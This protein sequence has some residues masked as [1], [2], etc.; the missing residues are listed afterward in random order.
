MITDAE[1]MHLLVGFKQSLKA[2][3]EGKAKKAL[4]SLDCD[5]KISAP[6]RNAASNANVELLEIPTMKE[7]GTICGIEVKASCAV[8]L[9]V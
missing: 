4:L 3:E 7:L 5:E 9:S 1:R 6:L 2:L 8:V